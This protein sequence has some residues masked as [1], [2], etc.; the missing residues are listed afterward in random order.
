M[1][2]M[3]RIPS[4]R[5][6]PRDLAIRY[7]NR[8]TVIMCVPMLKLDGYAVYAIKNEPFSVHPVAVHKA[9]GELLPLPPVGKADLISSRW[10]GLAYEIVPEHVLRTMADPPALAQ[11][12]TA[13]FIDVLPYAW[14]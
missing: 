1:S 2:F 3:F 11:R 9:N 12:W 6:T 8:G 4:Y 5:I 7:R 13:R 10:P 14:N